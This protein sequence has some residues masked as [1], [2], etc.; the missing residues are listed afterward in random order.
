[1]LPKTKNMGHIL[2]DVFK[3][4]V[5]I[6]G[7]VVIMM[8][9]IECF[10]VWS[11]GRFVGAFKGKGFW[12]ICLSAFLGAVPGC[13]GG[14]AVVS[15]YTHGMVSFGALVAMMIATSGDESFVMLAMMPDKAWW[16]MLALFVLAI[17][18]G[19]IIDL[20]HKPGKAQVTCSENF[21]V[22]E[23]DSHA[24]EGR[25]SFSW[26]R[27]L[28][29]FNVVLFIGLLVGGLLEHGH[30][31]EIEAPEGGI[32]LLSED[33]MN[34]LFAGLSLIVLAVLIFAKDHFVEE[35]IWHHIVC[36][37]LPSIFYWT[38]GTLAVIEL[39]LHYFNVADWINSN[40]ALMILLAAAIG[41]IP[42]SGPHL[43]F[44]TLFASGI[45]PLPVLLASCIS[46][47]GHAALPLLA[48][49]KRG[50]ITA[51]AINFLIALA[52]G[53]ATMLL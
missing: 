50:F 43:I 8:M 19:V 29:F 3:N 14:F 38:F 25:R 49:S 28:M 46:Q 37:H 45:V 2:L 22:H 39:G 27:A 33:W 52:A 11:K 44:V 30:G 18:V 7:L 51:K 20:V 13:M 41:I 34:Y 24:S 48:E 9:M 53:Y 10:N 17:I 32:N 6:T 12:Q 42:E 36:R 5:L 23:D 31:E 16:I 4:A 26:K 35:H 40:T 15:M 1:M 47:D 21:T